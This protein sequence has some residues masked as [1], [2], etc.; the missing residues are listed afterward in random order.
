VLPVVEAT[1]FP[2]VVSEDRGFIRI[3]ISG[4]T[5]RARRIGLLERIAAETKS[6]GINTVLVDSL[7]ST[8]EISTMERFDFGQGAA[9]TL[10]ASIKVAIVL[11]RSRA[12]R[13][14][15]TVA[16]NRGANIGVFADEAAALEWLTGS[17]VQKPLD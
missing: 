15:Q 14:A 9:R 16:Q 2:T 1:E 11:Q 6:R 17:G 5:S 13:F 7:G 4:P 3:T 10:G 8:G 12:D